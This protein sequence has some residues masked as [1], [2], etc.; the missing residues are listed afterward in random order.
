MAGEGSM[1]LQKGGGDAA[2][3]SWDLAADKV[4]AGDGLDTGKKVQPAPPLEAAK[5]LLNEG[6]KEVQVEEGKRIEVVPACTKTMSSVEKEPGRQ[7]GTSVVAVS[8]EAL[9]DKLQLEE[10]INAETGGGAIDTNDKCK[11]DGGDKTTDDIQKEDDVED[12]GMPDHDSAEDG[13]R[14]H[15]TD[16]E[17]Y[18]DSQESVDFATR[19]L[20]LMG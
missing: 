5:P 3:T 6:R 14:L 16:S 1:G 15:I 4:A 10:I 17:D 18:I 11:V 13:G 8:D 2:V 7:I 9:A 20:S 12:T 19:I